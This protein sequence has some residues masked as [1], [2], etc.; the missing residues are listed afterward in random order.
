LLGDA[1]G[2]DAGLDDGLLGDA[3]C[4]GLG[5]AVAPAAQEGS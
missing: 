3:I 1:V 4:V 5:T 2:G